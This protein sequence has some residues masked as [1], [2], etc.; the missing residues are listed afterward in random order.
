MKYKVLV[1]DDEFLIRMTL[2][3]G[4]SDRGYQVESA[5]G[6]REGLERA[7]AL[8]PHVVLL[9]NRLG[10]ERGMDAIAAFKQLDEEVA[11]ALSS[12]SPCL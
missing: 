1:V 12:F 4:L 10:S 11:L 7:E 2:E 3:S 8:R 5:S 6:V 9:D